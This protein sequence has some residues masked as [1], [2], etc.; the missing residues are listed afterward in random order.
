MPVNNVF[1]VNLNY[2]INQ[3]LDPE[4][5]DSVFHATSLHGAMKHVASNVKNIKDSLHRIGKYIRGKSLEDNPNN[6]KELEGVG[7][8]L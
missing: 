7:K 1:N 3:A 6:F 2:N 8:E 4:K 5:L